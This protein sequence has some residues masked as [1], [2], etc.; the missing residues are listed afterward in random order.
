MTLKT[1][2][3]AVKKFA[4]HSTNTLLFKIVI[5]NCNNILQYYC[6]FDRINEHC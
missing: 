1:G 6:I 4:L 2:G 3:M 5:L